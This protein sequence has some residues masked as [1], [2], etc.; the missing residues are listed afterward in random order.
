MKSF[1]LWPVGALTLLAV[2]SLQADTLPIDANVKFIKSGNDASTIGACATFVC[3][4]T[5]TAAIDG[6]GY[7]DIN[8]IN[9][10]G[11]TITGLEFF[12]SF[13]NFNQVFNASTNAF[14]NASIFPD[15]SGIPSS[16]LLNLVNPSVGVVGP[17][18]IVSFSGVGSS[19]TGIAPTSFPDPEDIAEG[20]GPLGFTPN[21]NIEV[22]AFFGS[23]PPPGST[24]T[25]LANGQSGSLELL[26]DAPE[27]RTL[28]ISLAGVVGLL[29]A[30]RKLQKA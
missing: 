21:G 18:L 7:A 19:G 8:I 3:E 25:G 12:I 20:P 15:E 4:T 27:P 26:A 24:F 29:V 6:A 13:G 10:S 17:S 11:K 5:L 23:A 14:E 16:I 1:R 9:E 28:W 22:L 2:A 30:K